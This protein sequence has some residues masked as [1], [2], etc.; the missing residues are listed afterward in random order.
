MERERRIGDKKIVL[1]TDT[2]V[3]VEENTGQQFNNEERKPG[4]GETMTLHEH[5][6]V[7][8]RDLYLSYYD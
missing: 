3:K 6:Q 5:L 1:N 7:A 8:R 2:K 4:D